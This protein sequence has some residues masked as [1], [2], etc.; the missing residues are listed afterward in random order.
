MTAQSREKARARFLEAATP[1]EAALNRGG[2][3]RVK[4]TTGVGNELLSWLGSG[5]TARPFSP[6]ADSMHGETPALVWVDEIWAFGAAEAEALQ[7]AYQP[8]FLTTRGQEW[9]TSTEGTEESVWVAE[10]KARGRAAVEEGG[11]RIAYFENSIPFTAA[12]ALE[13]SDAALLAAVAENHPSFGVTFGMSD[14][15]A[16]LEKS[17]SN[18]AGFVR[19]FGNVR[20]GSSAA[21]VVPAGVW[22][23]ARTDAPVPDPVGFGVAFDGDGVAVVA[24]G[25]DGDGVAVCEL[26]ATGRDGVVDYQGTRRPV[27]AFVEDLRAAQ[28]PVGVALEGSGAGRDLA[29]QL[30]DVLTLGPADLAAAFSRQFRGLG[31]REVTFRRSTVLDDSAERSATRAAAGGRWW[32]GDGSLPLRAMALAVWAIDHPSGPTGPFRILIPRSSRVR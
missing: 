17:R 21:R 24:A 23:G 25:R 30:D 19:S 16:A 5:G 18:R 6:S 4:L 29:D 2:K 13:L 3:R 14:L 7:I 26:V 8:G 12:E 27:R 10:V 9:L 28:R 15:E 32:D 1:V 11:S 31:T 20:S 22:S